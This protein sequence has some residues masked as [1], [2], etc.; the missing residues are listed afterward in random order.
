MKLDGNEHEVAERILQMRACDSVHANVGAEEENA[1]V[2]ECLTVQSARDLL[3][4]TPDVHMNDL[5]I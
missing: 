2:T 5:P 1:P 3:G 4:V